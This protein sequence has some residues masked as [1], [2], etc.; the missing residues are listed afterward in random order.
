M[1]DRAPLLSVIMSIRDSAAT[2]A[3]AGRSILAQSLQDWELIV[4]DDGSKDDGAARLAA[5]GDPRI[6]IVRHEQSRGLAC[7]L[8]EA[9]IL[10]RGA[11]IARMDADDVCYPDRLAAQVALLMREPALDLVACK[12]V[13]FRGAGELIGVFPVASE[14]TAIA[15][16]PMLGFR[17]P[18]PTW[19]GRAAWFR[20][21][22]YDER[23][24]RAQ[25]QELL[26]RT[27]AKSRFGTVDTILF[28]YRDERLDLGKCLKGR[29]L[30]ARALWREG[31]RSGQPAAALFGIAAQLAKATAEIL[32]SKLGMQSRMLRQRYEPLGADDLAQWLTVWASVTGT[33]DMDSCAA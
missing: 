29:L 32:T 7:R 30:F 6:R 18:H 20:D 31:G 3:A 22:P 8:N 26:L 15:A 23:M 4:I 33:L 13:V 16:N 5:I 21:N 14:H 1:S 10:S 28:G 2:V 24:T 27:A 11:F 9:V 19:C 12:A 25:D 17:F